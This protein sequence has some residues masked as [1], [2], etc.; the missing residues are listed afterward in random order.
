M[1]Y[2]G[3]QIYTHYQPT[4]YEWDVYL[5]NQQVAINPLDSPCN[6]DEH[7]LGEAQKWIDAAILEVES[8]TNHA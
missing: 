3:Y 7:A 5:D 6:N 2:K 8:G 4:G 1:D